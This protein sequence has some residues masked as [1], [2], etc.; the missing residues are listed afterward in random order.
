MRYKFR[1]IFLIVTTVLFIGIGNPSHAR[2]V[3]DQMG[4]QVTVPDKPQ[5][6]IALAPSITEIIYALGQENLLKG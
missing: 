3:T 5:R 1:A 6:V 4:R 2:I